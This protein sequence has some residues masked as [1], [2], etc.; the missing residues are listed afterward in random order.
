MQE[1]IT[2]QQLVATILDKSEGCFLWVK[3]VLRELRKVHSATATRR[4][5]EDVPQ[6]MDKLY[7]RTL[8]AMST[9]SYGKPLAKAILTWA[10]CS[11]RP[12]TT[13]ELKHA[14]KIDVDDTVP[15]LE[16]QIA[17]LC[18]H[19]VYVDSQ[20]RIKTV[21]QTARSFLL[22]PDTYSEFAFREQDGHRQLAVTCLK[23]LLDDEM[24]APRSRRPSAVQHNAHRSPFLDYAA[25]SFY[26]HVQRSSSTDK[27]L[28]AL[29]YG[30]LSS[31][32][33][34][35]QSWIEYIA[36]SGD[37]NPLIRTGIT[38][39]TYL[40]RRAKHFPALGKEVQ[41]V[42]SWSTDLIRIVAKFGRNLLRFPPSIYHII[43]PFCP[44]EAA[45]YRQFGTSARGI[46]VMGLSS[47]TW[48]DCL[49][50]I[51]CH[52]SA[53]TA[54]ACSG[55]HFAIGAS[56]KLI[57]LYH[58]ATCQEFG[59]LEHG[60]PVKILEFNVSGQLLTSTGRKSVRVWDVAAKQS[61]WHF[62]TSRPCI[63]VTFT[64]DNKALILAC[65]DNH[66]Y[67]YDLVNGSCSTT[68]Q[69]YMDVGHIKPI[70]R[71]PDSAA[72][73]LERKLLAF[74]Y[75]GGHI[76]L[77]NWEDSFFVGT[78]EKPSARKETLPFH[79]SSLV[80]NPAPNT[81]SLAA[82]YEGGELIVFDPLEGDIKAVYKAD[83]DAQTLACSPD[84]RTLISGDSSGTI[85]IFD[86][87]AFDSQKLKLLYIIYGRGNNIR[88][89]AFCSD[90][91]R[92]V[93]IRGPQSN[94]WEPA[95]LARQDVGE[96]TSDTVSVELQEAPV[97]EAMEV[98]VITAIAFEPRGEYIFCGTE[99]GLIT[100][101]ETRNGR[102]SQV[103]YKHS[104]GVSITK[105]AFE[106]SKDIIASADSSSK[107]LVHQ[108]ILGPTNWKIKPLLLEYRM[109]DPVEQL[110]FSPDG[111][112]ILIVTTSN[113]TICA[114][115]GSATTSI[116][117]TTRN[118]GIWA[119]HPQHPTQ[120]LLIVNDRLRVYDWNGL[121]E[122]TAG[123]GIELDIEIPP[124]FEIRRSYCGWN[125]AILAT[126]YSELSRSRSRIRLI[127]WDTTHLGI[128]QATASPHPALQPFGDRLAY[129]F[130][131]FGTMI[132][133]TRGSIVFLD[134]DGWVCSVDMEN[135]MP[136]Y[137][138]R[139]FFLPHDWLSTNDNLL[140]GV[141]TGHDIIYG[142]EHEL[143]VIKRGLECIRM[144]PFELEQ[145]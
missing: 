117:W 145:E 13:P 129:L 91:L 82:A 58:T 10:V 15:N 131:T 134:H 55:S 19:L 98:D 111:T 70:Y 37:L 16:N 139:H 36:S 39:R 140:F 92:F 78:C 1:H 8:T 102:Q 3:L 65:H 66:L 7:G 109:E 45:P 80:F 120:L 56:D 101:F 51:V 122:L 76:N 103:L 47:P 35:V 59:K 29:L 99:Y 67:F 132:G 115:D 123:P 2:R 144:V 69:W 125:G 32:N 135:S 21:H 62:Q 9:S 49:A 31:S 61:I 119:N 79:A 43:P 63:A 86:F 33:G 75:R 11:V 73:S 105:L 52:K 17:S 23:Y 107:V 100:I 95:V 126:E 27:E 71:T 141:T 48:D 121:K 84:G 94:V 118:A 138:R 77:W 18:G 26:E 127:L 83:A 25:R 72:F 81:D 124:E 143:A 130:G 41:T 108:L 142:K 14:L 42:D 116:S 53:T 28:L 90:N 106:G 89:L 24:K 60:E 104:S 97:A 85:R 113:D 57:R 12:L 30:F 128:S 112:K 44:R 93:D 6:G 5:L 46:S 64:S 88:A 50:C 136:K 4:I 110:L 96:E 40:K 54:V 22:S 87:E 38:L 20:F 133:I 34:N 74:V 137:Y 114:L 68:E